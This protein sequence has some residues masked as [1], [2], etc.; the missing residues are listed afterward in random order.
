MTTTTK[1]ENFKNRYALVRGPLYFRIFGEGGAWTPFGPT[2]DA[3]L[4]LG[5][6]KATLIS[7]DDGSVLDEQ[8]TAKTATFSVT[9]QSL[10]DSNLAIALQ[11]AIRE[12]AAK[13]DEPVTVP[14]LVAGQ[15]FFLQFA[16]VTKLTFDSLADGV[17]YSL[18]KS[19]G[20]IT[21]LKDTVEAKGTYSTAATVEMGIL[22]NSGIELELMYD[23]TGS[24]GMRLQMFKW[25]PSPAQNIA[26]NAGNEHSSLAVTGALVASDAVS[27]DEMLGKFGRVV[28]V[29]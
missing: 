25:K 21:A 6:E 18:D 20:R 3:S 10:S 4:E 27:S 1:V 28:R 22:A 14:S 13:T 2:K 7:G 5:V 12:I 8:Q 26:I 23:A 17:D 11:S 29:S 16:N 15:T 24:G 19:S 9:L